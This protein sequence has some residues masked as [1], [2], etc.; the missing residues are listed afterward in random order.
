MA[1]DFLM[2]NLTEAPGATLES[3]GLSVFSGVG[4]TLIEGGTIVTSPATSWSE[5]GITVSFV[6]SSGGASATHEVGQYIT[7][8]CFV[9]APGGLYCHYTPAADLEVA[10]GWYHN[11]A[12]VNPDVGGVGVGG[13]IGGAYPQGWANRWYSSAGDGGYDHSLNDGWGV[14]ASAPM[15]IPPDQTAVI[16]RGATAGANARPI[17]ESAIYITVVSTA[18]PLG[19]FRPAPWSGC[20]RDH[21]YLESQIDYGTLQNLPSLTGPPSFASLQTRLRGPWLDPN[22]GEAGWLMRSLHP[23]ENMPG[24]D[25]M[26]QMTQYTGTA[27]LLLNTSATNSQK[28]QLLIYLIQIGL[29]YYE[30]WENMQNPIGTTAQVSGGIGTG[31]LFP[32]IFA[33]TV[34]GNSTVANAP[35]NNF[36]GYRTGYTA[37]SGSPP[38]GFYNPNKWAACEWGQVFVVEE[39]S[40]GVYN[41]GYGGYGAADVGMPCWAQEHEYNP[42]RDDR[43]WGAAYRQCCTA[44]QWKDHVLASHIMGIHSLW[45]YQPLLDYTDRYMAACAAVAPTSRSDDAW[46]ELMWDT[47]RSPY[48]G[49]VFDSSGYYPE[50]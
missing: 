17:L 8:D 46:T 47:Y 27:A 38:A 36:G 49:A 21:P 10:T 35:I 2:G 22:P 26:A 48:G 44:M 20:R 11:G 6:E 28:R 25:Y 1:H 15:Y 13:A 4:G 5:R 43:A 31:R 42:T 40:P 14:T 3:D 30:Q 16:T 50:V 37:P 18:P 45:G 32:Q 39:T 9:V 19:A 33:G 29:D 41:D 23:V 34:L 7:G 24:M 12:M